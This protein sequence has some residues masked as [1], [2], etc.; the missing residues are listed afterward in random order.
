MSSLYKPLFSCD[1]IFQTGL[2]GNLIVLTVFY[3]GGLMMNEA[4]ISVG[5]LSAFLLYAAY[6]GISIGGMLSIL[7]SCSTRR[8]CVVHTKS[9]SCFV[10][11]PEIFLKV[12]SSE[13]FT[14]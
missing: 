14:I 7:I 13:T 10:K 11:R 2:S 4:V 3:K 1:I 8:C 6:V 9:N 12:F 5:D